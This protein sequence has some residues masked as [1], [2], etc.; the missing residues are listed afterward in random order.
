MGHAA[1]SSRLAGRDRLTTPDRFPEPVGPENNVVENV[2]LLAGYVQVDYDAAVQDARSL[3][4]RAAGLLAANAVVLTIAATIASSAHASGSP[5]RVSLV[6]AAVFAVLSIV[7]AIVGAL[8]RPALAI[9]ISGFREFFTREALEQE[10]VNLK[11]RL[12]AARMEQLASLR[13]VNAAAAPWLGFANFFLV[14]GLVALAFTV[15][16]V[17]VEPSHPD[18]TH[19]VI[20]RIVPRQRLSSTAGS[21][22]NW[23]E[24]ACRDSPWA[25]GRGHRRTSFRGWS[26]YEPAYR[27]CHH[28]PKYETKANP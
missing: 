2:K 3:A 22:S 27:L 7:V 13:K 19:V 16:W 11:G 1:A 23:T 21:H 9:S 26:L 10:P 6:A 17:A 8:P 20:D 25:R 12:A 18:A 24:K 15:G 4:T 28:E 14:V 5:G